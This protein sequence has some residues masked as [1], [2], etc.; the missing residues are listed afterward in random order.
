MNLP[1]AHTQNFDPGILPETTADG[2]LVVWVPDD[3]TYSQPTQVTDELGHAVTY[4]YDK[5]NRVLTSQDPAQAAAGKHIT[6]TY[7]DDGNLTSVTD[8]NDHVTS[9]AYDNRDRL[10]GIVDPVNQGTGR[11]TTLVYDAA[12]TPSPMPTTT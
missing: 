5:A 4:T 11:Q 1:T 8:A 9:Y 12:A 3:P 10:V 2:R 7:D 6:D